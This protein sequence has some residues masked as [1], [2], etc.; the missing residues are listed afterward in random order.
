V[1][2]AL[3]GPR[4]CDRDGSATAQTF[5][6]TLPRPPPQHPVRHRRRRH[7][8]STY[9]DDAYGKRSLT[10]T[11][12]TPFGFTGQYTDT[13]TGHIYLNIAPLPRRR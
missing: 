6:V 3:P 10:R 11:S 5:D 9:S 7:D 8:G 1:R 4:H 2:A 13:D 12:I